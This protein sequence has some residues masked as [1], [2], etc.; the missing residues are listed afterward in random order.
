MFPPLYLQALKVFKNYKTLIF[1]CDGVIL[2]S[3]SLKTSAFHKTVIE[4]G[5]INASKLVKFHKMN[6]GI[7]RYS[8]FEYYL[9][10]INS[11]SSFSMDELLQKY[12]NLVI[13]G[14]LECNTSKGFDLFIKQ[15]I[16]EHC[17]VV[18]GGDQSE[19][20]QVFNVRNLSHF[21]N[22]GIFGSPCNK[23]EIIS[24]EIKN[25]NI[26]FP[27]VFFGDSKYDL[28]VSNKF[29]ID[30][31]F[32]SELSDIADAKN[33]CIKNKINNYSNFNEVK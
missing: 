1:D 3:N 32:L 15:N 11:E 8:K 12:K 7:S 22:G 13:N 21:F 29:G 18:S 2:D 17:L 4:D 5:A 25:G 14:L 10:S 28:E 24:R 33:W 19:L 26:V 6:G 27:A 16:N 20:N 30:F 31:I 9:N 23:E